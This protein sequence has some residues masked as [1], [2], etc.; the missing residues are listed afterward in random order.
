M[1]MRWEPFFF[2]KGSL[3]WPGSLL[4]ILLSKGSE[5][6]RGLHGARFLDRSR[7]TV[8][9]VVEPVPVMVPVPVVVPVP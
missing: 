4:I 3:G 6:P 9:P 8:V 1:K 5:R 7:A 2:F